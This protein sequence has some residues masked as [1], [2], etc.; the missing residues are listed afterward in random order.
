V[1]VTV[2]VVIIVMMVMRCWRAGSLS[3]RRG[4]LLTLA[5]SGC[6]CCDHGCKQNAL[7]LSHG[8]SPVKE[9]T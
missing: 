5:A 9:K 3:L 1:I 6:A 7:K 2:I 4:G 8:S